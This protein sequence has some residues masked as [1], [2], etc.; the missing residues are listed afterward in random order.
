MKRFRS[1]HFVCALFT[2]FFL[3]GCVH[4]NDAVRNWP[5]GPNRFKTPANKFNKSKMSVVGYELIQVRGPNPE[6][7]ASRHDRLV[8]SGKIPFS[9]RVDKKN[10]TGEISPPRTVTYNPSRWRDWGA[11]QPA[12]M[13]EKGHRYPSAPEEVNF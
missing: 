11:D 6:S 4:Q 3:V 8:R 10:P 13:Q 9:P 2:V 5:A 1:M 7:E 12:V